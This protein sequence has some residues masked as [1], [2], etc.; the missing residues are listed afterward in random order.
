MHLLINK[1]VCINMKKNK[2]VYYVFIIQVCTIKFCLGRQLHTSAQNS[3]DNSSKLNPHNGSKLENIYSNLIE[4]NKFI[5]KSSLFKVKQDVNTEHNTD[6]DTKF[7]NCSKCNRNEEMSKTTDMYTKP[8]NNS[9]SATKSTSTYSYPDDTR[10]DNNTSKVKFDTDKAIASRLNAKRNLLMRLNTM[11]SDSS[12]IPKNYDNQYS[13]TTTKYSSS[14]VPYDP[15]AGYGNQSA[16]YGGSGGY[17]MDPNAGGGMGAAPMA[18]STPGMTTDPSAGGMGS[19]M[20]PGMTGGSMDPSMGG[21]MNNSMAPQGGSYVPESYP[22]PG[23]VPGS[24]YP[25]G[26]TNAGQPGYGNDNPY[27]YSNDWYNGPDTGYGNGAYPTNPTSSTPY[28]EKDDI[29]ESFKCKYLAFFFP[30]CT[31]SRPR[32]MAPPPLGQMSPVSQQ[33]CNIYGTTDLNLSDFLCNVNEWL[34]VNQNN[35]I[36]LTSNKPVSTMQNI[37]LKGN[38]CN[39]E[40]LSCTLQLGENSTAGLSVRGMNGERTLIELNSLTKTISLKQINNQTTQILLE[41][42]Y[43]KMNSNFLHLVQ[44]NDGG[45]QGTL[46]VFV[47]GNHVFSKRDIPTQ[48]TGLMGMFISSGNATFGNL[49]VTPS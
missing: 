48:T 21:G 1:I 46:S 33:Y 15:N 17:G 49:S 36:R 9:D 32:N 12:N 34:V 3:S 14:N 28:S 25:P 27:G 5:G 23:S 22:A 4:T 16:G 6:Q 2:L 10:D 24:S 44:V 30:E 26:N 45:F 37:E 11:A 8:A 42:P 41:T 39:K 40:S 43:S 31:D 35:S 29:H 13:G 19:T 18:G 20:S 38:Y 7:N 47:D